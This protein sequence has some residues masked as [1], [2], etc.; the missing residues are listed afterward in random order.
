METWDAIRA[1]RNVR[2]F[3]QRP[4]GDEHLERILEAGG[5]RSP[6]PP[7]PPPPFPP[8]APRPP[9]P[10]HRP[11]SKAADPSPRSYTATAGEVRHG[12]L[13]LPGGRAHP[14]CS[15]I[16]TEHVARVGISSAASAG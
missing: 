14:V 1:R 11:K 13:G 7:P 3:E 9:P 12:H 6:P 16:G 10:G 2:E 5:R 15:S 4:L 8:A